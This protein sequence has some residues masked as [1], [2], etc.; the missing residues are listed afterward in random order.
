MR[1]RLVSWQLDNQ[2]SPANAMWT[3]LQFTTGNVDAD[4]TALA[5]NCY[6]H[7]AISALMLAGTIY[8]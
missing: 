3:Q 6:H 8:A 1:Q 7:G 5:V 4:G 2:R